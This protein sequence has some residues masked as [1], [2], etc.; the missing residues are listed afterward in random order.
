MVFHYLQYTRVFSPFFLEHFLHF[1]RQTLVEGSRGNMGMSP[2]CFVRFSRFSKEVKTY[3][4][5]GGHLWEVENQA[6]AKK[7]NNYFNFI[8]IS[9]DNLET[10]WSGDLVE[11]FSLR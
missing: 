10:Q 4:L 9:W 7:S 8:A 5:Y 11:K 3:A 1:F 2:I 6:W